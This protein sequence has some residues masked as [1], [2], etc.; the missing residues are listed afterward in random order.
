[1][2]PPF[3]V[4]MSKARGGFGQVRDRTMQAPTGERGFGGLSVTGHVQA[5]RGAADGES[6]GED[7]QA[8]SERVA[9]SVLERQTEET[10]AGASRPP[11]PILLQQNVAPNVAPRP[12]RPRGRPQPFKKSN[13]TKGSRKVEK[14]RGNMVRGLKKSLGAPP[15]WR[16]PRGKTIVSL[17]NSHSNATRIGWHLWE[18][19]LRFAPGLPPG[20]PSTTHSRVS[21]DSFYY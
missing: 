3:P 7:G 15:P 11:S 4:C 12:R 6:S 1:M 9:S 16:Q 2:S 13:S 10:A 21:P 14:E 20:W 18:I 8:G 19:D 17:V 5:L